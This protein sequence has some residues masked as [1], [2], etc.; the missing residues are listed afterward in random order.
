MRD[1]TCVL[2]LLL[3]EDNTVQVSLMALQVGQN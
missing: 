1:F 2:R 3:L